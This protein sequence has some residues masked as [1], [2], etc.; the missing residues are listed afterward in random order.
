MSSQFPH[1]RH[2]VGALGCP[3]WR[4]VLALI[5]TT[6]LAL[7]LLLTQP[8]TGRAQAAPELQGMPRVE[9]VAMTPEILVAQSQ[10]TLRVHVSGVSFDELQGKRLR[11]VVQADPFMD[12]SE[13]DSF[14]ESGRGDGWE[15]QEVILSEQNLVAAQNT[16]AEGAT[17]TV[18]IPTADMPLWNEEAWGPYGVTVL[19]MDT[20]YA[21]ETGQNPTGRTLLL[22]YPPGSTGVSNVNAT[23]TGTHDIPPSELTP[24]NATGVTLTLSGTEIESLLKSPSVNPTE[25][26]LLPE[27][28]ASLSLLA[29]TSQSDLYALAEDSRGVEG[30]E[31]SNGTD[32]NGSESQSSDQGQSDPLEQDLR[33]AGISLIGDVV[34][35]DE[36][37]MGLRTL[38]KAGEQPVLSPPGGMSTFG[39]T[40]VTP[41]SRF[42]VDLTTG[43]TVFDDA[44]PNTGTVLASWRDGVSA[45]SE[46]RRAALG[47]NELSGRQRTRAF[48]AMA[49]QENPQDVLDL[50][51][52]AV[53]SDLGPDPSERLAELLDA[54][55]VNPVSLEEMLRSPR[56]GIERWPLHDFATV[57][58]MTT[59]EQLD[60]LTA[61][62]AKYEAVVSAAATNPQLSAEI[63]NN[64]LS[65]TAANLT[66]EERANLVAA[67]VYELEA[68]T[69]VISIVPSATVNVIGKNVPFP[70]TVSNSGDVTLRLLVGLETSDPRLHAG[71]W[72]EAIV[73]AHGS[74][75]V[76]IPV[77]AVGAG[78]VGVV[79][80]AKTAQ[81]VRLDASEEITVNVRAN[82]EDAG[83]WVVG[84]T[85]VAFFAFGLVRTVR[86]GRRNKIATS[87]GTEG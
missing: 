43:A 16:G 42:L 22:W 67:A 86:K 79:V 27:A 83:T 77:E 45:I 82:L 60:L 54:P 24:L 33:R 85:L 71:D 46:E 57:N 48:S 55:W 68:Q 34:V 28:N 26:V 12:S 8:L 41:S 4:A 19:L 81:D 47:L 74:V 20:D 3:A 51:V 62:V 44:A 30:L 63:L 59:R 50:Y 80:V 49:V 6:A 64:V 38:Q 21:A 29:T 70:I 72:V 76:H 56:S 73:P 15:A 36:G 87:G 14:L 78:Q 11:T 53:F 25:V 32:T 39:V 10:V 9:V 5:L 52:N 66:E 1:A 61:R 35:A 58:V 31:G 2:R 69:N 17:I 23:V 13:V 18:T 40:G 84:G 75:T 7:M 37:W 65:A